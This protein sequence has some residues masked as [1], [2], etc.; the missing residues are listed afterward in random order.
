MLASTDIQQM[1]KNMHTQGAKKWIVK[2]K[3]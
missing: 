3:F 2:I 1:L